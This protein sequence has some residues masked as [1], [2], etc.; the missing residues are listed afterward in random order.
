[1]DASFK[2]S[3]KQAYL[4]FARNDENFVNDFAVTEMGS[5]LGRLYAIFVLH[6]MGL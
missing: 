6:N 2:Q 1:M 3:Q 4:E 5:V